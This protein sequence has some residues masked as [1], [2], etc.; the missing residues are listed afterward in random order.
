MGIKKGG[1]AVGR[2]KPI[3]KEKRH[4]QKEATLSGRTRGP[5]A[6]RAREIREYRSS[7]RERSPH[8]TSQWGIRKEMCGPC[9]RERQARGGRDPEAV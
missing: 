2:A 6:Q 4:D 5:P 9:S 1:S 8:G 3:K 7:K